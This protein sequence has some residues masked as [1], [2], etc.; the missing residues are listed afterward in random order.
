MAKIPVISVSNQSQQPAGQLTVST[1]RTGGAVPAPRTSQLRDDSAL[2]RA[3]GAE[4][5]INTVKNASF[6]IAKKQKQADDIRYVNEA[7]ADARMISSDA[8]ER[9]K[10]ENRSSPLGLSDKF[11]DSQPERMKRLIENA[12]SDAAKQAIDRQISNLNASMYIGAKQDENNLFAK[13]VADSWDKLTNNAAND[14]ARDPSS[15][16]FSKNVTDVLGRFDIQAQTAFQGE[17]LEQART[18]AVRKLS[19]ARIEVLKE[20]DPDAALKVLMQEKSMS[21]MLGGI[22]YIKQV[23]DTKRAVYQRR[24]SEYKEEKKLAN[25]RVNELYA[26]ITDMV[27]VGATVDISDVKRY[28][29]DFI[30]AGRSKDYLE[31]K[32]IVQSK[33]VVTD[34]DIYRDLSRRILDGKDVYQDLQIASSNRQIS[35]G[36]YKELMKWNQD[37]H[38]A[39]KLGEGGDNAEYGRKIVVD[40]MTS[41]G[42]NMFS[43]SK[44]DAVKITMA[45]IEYDQIVS[46]FTQQEGRTPTREE[47]RSFAMDVFGGYKKDTLKK[48]F[49]VLPRPRDFRGD[50]RS[51]IN[52]EASR[53]RMIDSYLKTH[54]LPTNT[55]NGTRKSFISDLIKSDFMFKNEMKKYQDILNVI[56]INEQDKSQKG[57]QDVESEL[58]RT[59]RR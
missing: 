38:D 43:L 51:R 24:A 32:K 22:E 40:L 12:P 44:D 16:N 31:L 25:E 21:E 58:M 17:A 15:A 57:T 23:Q 52:V 3:E 18:K 5:L 8:L 37:N 49:D 42:G 56:T 48:S 46:D 34:S 50:V 45:K 2:I 54:R 35:S 30:F 33:D 13:A 20:R 55:D 19:Q 9:I 39:G 6:E 14:I 28:K 4:Q 7:Y 1:P 47:A 53:Q 10:L 41:M 36:D 27:D 11:L 59:D 26:S 29:D